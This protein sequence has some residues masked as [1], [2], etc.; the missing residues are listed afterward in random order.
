MGHEWYYLAIRDREAIE[1]L[2]GV[3]ENGDFLVVFQETFFSLRDR[4][5]RKLS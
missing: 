4:E 2:K 3:F 1:V 5:N